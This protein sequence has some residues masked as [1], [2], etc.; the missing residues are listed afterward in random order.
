MNRAFGVSYLINIVLQSFWCLLFPIG[1]ALGLGLFMVNKLSWPSWVMI[2]PLIL[3]VFMGLFSMC[4][5]LISAT[6][7]MD[8]MEKQRAADREAAKRANVERQKL[9]DEL[10]LKESD[11][12]KAESSKD[13]NHG[14]DKI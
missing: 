5:F 10:A 6:D 13:G 8:R 2:P 3:A 14:G 1:I 4:K 11:S 7:A 12:T 9:K